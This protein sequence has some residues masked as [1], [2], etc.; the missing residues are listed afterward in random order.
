MR[1]ATTVAA[2]FPKEKLVRTATTVAAKFPKENT[3]E[4][5][6]RQLRSW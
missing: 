3:T 2:K 6:V 5:L 1:T 4:E